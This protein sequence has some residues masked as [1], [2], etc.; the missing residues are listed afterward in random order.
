MCPGEDSSSAQLAH[1][2]QIGVVHFGVRG[3]LSFS[4]S[5]EICRRTFSVAYEICLSAWGRISTLPVLLLHFRLSAYDCWAL[6][7][8]CSRS[9]YGCRRHACPMLGLAA[10]GGGLR[11]VGSCAL[12][13]GVVGGSGGVV[14]G[15]GGVVGGNSG[16]VV[17]DTGGVKGS[18]EV[19]GIGSDEDDGVGNSGGVFAS[20]TGK[21]SAKGSD[22]VCVKGSD[23]VGRCMGSGRA[24]GA[25]IGAGSG[26]AIGSDGLV[27][28]PGRSACRA[29]AAIGG[30]SGHENE[31]GS[32]CCCAC[33]GG[34]GGGSGW[35]IWGGGAVEAEASADRCALTASSCRCRRS[36]FPWANW[37]LRP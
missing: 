12:T 6:C 31:T 20:G 17:V 24:S 9:S 5:D 19:D 10:T 23:V 15:S 1:G 14:G 4:Q 36:S 25:D 18:D 30:A 2:V 21:G 27:G 3:S 16:G 22:V 11:K 13:G 35:N 37:H 26:H 34:Y 29:C 7:A 8:H 32:T 33:C 28:V